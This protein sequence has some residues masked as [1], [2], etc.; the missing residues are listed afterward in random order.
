MEVPQNIRNRNL[1]GI[2]LWHR[3]LRIRCCH[4]NSLGHCCGAGLIPGPGTSTCRERSQKEKKK[5]KEKES[6]YAPAFLLLA[7]N[8]KELRESPEKYLHIHALRSIIR[9]NREVEATQTSVDR[10]MDK[11]KMA[12]T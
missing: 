11:P 1:L 7:Y 8:P 4:Y 2:R 6:P 10:Q 3:R 5:K 12:Y 9:N